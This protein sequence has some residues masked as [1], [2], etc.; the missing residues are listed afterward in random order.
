MINLEQ[1]STRGRTVTQNNV[2]VR[3]IRFARTTTQNNGTIIV[4]G[5]GRMP[6]LKKLQVRGKLK[7][8]QKK[9]F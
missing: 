6:Y 8:N 2:G 7:N 9:F 4:R 1:S 3:G 5:S